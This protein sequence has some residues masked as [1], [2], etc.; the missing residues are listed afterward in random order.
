[1]PVT[2]SNSVFF[3]IASMACKDAQAFIQDLRA[4]ILRSVSDDPSGYILVREDIE[5]DV[6]LRLTFQVGS[7]NTDEHFT[8]AS[9]QEKVG[10]LVLIFFILALGISPNL[11]VKLVQVD[12]VNLL[13]RMN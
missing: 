9:W 11:W 8:D 13:G 2:S 3:P 5:C 7:A 1:M 4:A 6:E 12:I 10:A